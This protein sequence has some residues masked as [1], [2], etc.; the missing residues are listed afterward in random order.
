MRASR[1]LKRFET[2][3]SINYG[4]L[5]ILRVGSIAIAI[6]HLPACMWSLQAVLVI[7]LQNS[8]VERLGY[9]VSLFSLRRPM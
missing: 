3:V 8:W 9:C 7:S 4:V 5:Q 6:A 2:R 1:I